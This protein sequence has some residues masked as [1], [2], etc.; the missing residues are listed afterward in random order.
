[1]HRTDYT[2]NVNTNRLKIIVVC[3][4]FVLFFKNVLRMK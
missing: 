2:K 4:F 1:M 3:G